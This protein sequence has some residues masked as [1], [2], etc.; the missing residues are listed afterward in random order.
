MIELGNVIRIFKQ[1]AEFI[2]VLYK[3]GYVHND[4]KPNN[5]VL[6]KNDKDQINIKVIDLGD[7]NNKLY[8]RIA[9]PNYFNNPHRRNLFGRLKYSDF[10]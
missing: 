8:P 6:F 1:I 7:L 2:I 5:I 4:L 3:K 10:I 9:T